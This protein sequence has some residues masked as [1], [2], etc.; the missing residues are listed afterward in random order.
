MAGVGVIGVGA[1]IL[2]SLVVGG[3]LLLLAQ[4]T[5]RLPEFALGFGLFMLGGVDYLLN[6]LARS[7]GLLDD[8]GRRMAMIAAV[9]CGAAGILAIAIF[10][11]RVFRPDS[12]GA[13][14]LV[15][16]FGLGLAGTGV[17]QG[18]STGYLAVATREDPAFFLRVFNLLQ[19]AILAWTAGESIRYAG[20]LRR[21]LG[22]GLVVDPTVLDRVRLWGIASAV[23]SAIY[24]LYAVAE[25]LGA[26]LLASTVGNLL[27][28]GL[29]L[30]SAGSIALAF[31]PPRGYQEWVRARSR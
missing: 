7:E 30:S 10:T 24:L 29:G 2:V 16:A 12:R 25:A 28:A 13:M 20:V 17:A 27:L 18:V 26:D 4:R 15:A 8:G 23:A 14:L 31:M 11:A 19:S 1:F 22:L 6:L 5:R 3:R 9:H 21:R